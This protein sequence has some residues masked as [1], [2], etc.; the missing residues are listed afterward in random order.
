MLRLDD[1]RKPIDRRPAPQEGPSSGIRSVADYPLKDR[2]QLPRSSGL[3]VEF[4]GSIDGDIDWLES[5][6]LDFIKRSQRNA[7]AAGQIS[8]LHRG[9][10]AQD[11]QSCPNPFTQKAHCV[12]G[13]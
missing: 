1:A 11:L 5:D 6:G 10:N 13:G 4:V 7:H 12:G 3:S 8:G 2:Q 9:W